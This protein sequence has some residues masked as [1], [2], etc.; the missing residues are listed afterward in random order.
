MGEWR[1]STYSGANGGDCIE[2]ASTDMIMVRDTKNPDGAMLKVSAGD[3]RKF[4][5]SLK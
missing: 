4:T 2:V 1:K 3:W 5:D